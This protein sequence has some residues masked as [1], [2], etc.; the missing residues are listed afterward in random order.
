MEQLYQNELPFDIDTLI[1]MTIVVDK[2]HF[3]EFCYHIV[4][5]EGNNGQTASKSS[6]LCFC[7]V[8]TNKTN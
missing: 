6:S 8:E 2:I 5:L 7:T 3:V 1:E 4:K